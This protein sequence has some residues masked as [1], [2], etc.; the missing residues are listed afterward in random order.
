MGWLVGGVWVGVGRGGSLLVPWGWGISAEKEAD[1][2]RPDGGI[3]LTTATTEADVDRATAVKRTT[4]VAK[5]HDIDL[6]L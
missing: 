1:V 5:L 6:D 2:D 3:K 4:K